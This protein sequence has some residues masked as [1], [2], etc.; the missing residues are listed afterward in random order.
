MTSI[1]YVLILH[2]QPFPNGGRSDIEVD[3]N[4]QH[5]TWDHKILYADRSLNEQLLI[6][7]FV[8]NMWNLADDLKLKFIFCFVDATRELLYLDK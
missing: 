8:E 1:P 5:L 3:E 6:I 7:Q 2:L 4:L